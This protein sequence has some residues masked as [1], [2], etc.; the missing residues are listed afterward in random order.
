MW[1][2]QCPWHC[3]LA[4]KLSHGAIADAVSGGWLCKSCIAFLS[5]DK[6][7]WYSLRAKSF[8]KRSMTSSISEAGN[9]LSHQYR[10]LQKRQLRL[11]VLRHSI[12]HHHQHHHFQ[13]FNVHHHHLP[14]A[15]TITSI[16][17]PSSTHL[18]P[19]SLPPPPPPLHHHHFVPYA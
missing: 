5:S 7:S 13:L 1:F 12:H 14:T 19:L 11:H 10:R 6:E 16:P 8:C 15:I 2:L 17:P 3:R 9:E 4:H 18:V